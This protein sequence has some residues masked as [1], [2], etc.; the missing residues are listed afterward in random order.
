MSPHIS[1]PSSITHLVRGSE[2]NSDC[3]R[4]TTTFRSGGSGSKGIAALTRTPYFLKIILG[5]VISPIETD[6]NSHPPAP[7][8]FSLVCIF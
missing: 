6:T 5:S 3:G 4:R 2:V 1:S 7:N 8:S